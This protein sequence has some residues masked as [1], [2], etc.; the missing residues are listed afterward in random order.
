[1]QVLLPRVVS[2]RPM[3]LSALLMF[4]LL[5]ACGSDKA[6]ETPAEKSR[7]ETIDR[8]GIRVVN[9]RQRL[10]QRECTKHPEHE[11]PGIYF[12]AYSPG[13]IYMDED[14]EPEEQLRTKEATCTVVEYQ[15]D[16]HNENDSDADAMILVE[17]LDRDDFVYHVQE[18]ELYD[19]PA[20]SMRPI[21]EDTFRGIQTRT[22]RLADESGDG[23]PGA[24]G[25]GAFLEMRSFTEI[26]LIEG[27]MK[28]FRVR[29]SE[30]RVK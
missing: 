18:H 24:F 14:E 12:A 9:L 28:Q 25:G 17:L 30:V 10:A 1:M 23:P 11:H 26:P 2:T 15:F 19:L 20:K 4:G 21:S 27:R 6:D 16:V 13:D 5:I 22:G 7:T 8:E 3:M 29:V